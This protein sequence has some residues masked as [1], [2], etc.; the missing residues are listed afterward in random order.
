M[1]KIITTFPSLMCLVVVFLLSG[2]IAHSGEG[3]FLD[4]ELLS[5]NQLVL[6]NERYI[7]LTLTDLS[8]YPTL[9]EAILNI[10]DPT[11]NITQIFIEISTDEM[12]LIHTEILHTPDNDTYNY[13]AY[14]EY[15]FQISFAV[16]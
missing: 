1:S 3:G 4:L 2:C 12:N 16:P 7:N 5:E 8:P 14:D 13:I 6:F 9:K 11:T 15:L 10:T